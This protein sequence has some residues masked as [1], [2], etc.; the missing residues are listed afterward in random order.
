MALKINLKDGESIYLGM[1]K[2]TVVHDGSYTILVIDGGDLPVMKQSET[3]TLD[4]ADTSEKRIYY[5]LQQHYLS[6]DDEHLRI[7]EAAAEALSVE[8][9]VQF[10]NALG[11]IK[12]SKPFAGLRA[13][14]RLVG[15]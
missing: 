12:G 5:H 11:D 10:E 4:D 6:G 14:R 13:M 3:I 1:S 2:L 8:D 9:Y 15:M 7:A